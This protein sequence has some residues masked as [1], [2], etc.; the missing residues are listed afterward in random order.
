[1]VAPAETRSRRP[2]AAA[3]ARLPTG[4]KL[5]A[6]LSAALLP[7]ALIITFAAYQTTRASD[8]ENRTRLRVAAAESARTLTIELVG[9]MNALR[10][11]LEAVESDPDDRLACAR[12]RG[13]FAP[14][15]TAGG[16]FGVYDAAGNLRCGTA[17]GAAV[18]PGESGIV[19]D[20]DPAGGLTLA[21]A[22]STG[23]ARAAAF[24]PTAFLAEVGRPSGFIPQFSARLRGDDAA[25]Y[26]RRLD[27]SPLARRDSIVEPIGIEGLALEME[28]PAAP[29][30]SPALIAML[31]PLLMWLVAAAVGWFV[32]DRLLIRP[33]RRLSR[34][35]QLY[36]PGTPFEAISIG[37][38]P[39]QEIRELDQ[40]FLALGRTVVAHESD[41][42]DG[43]VR[44]TRLT[45]E[46][47]H[48]V[49]NNLQVIASLI[50]FHARSAAD[51]P[52]VTAAYASIQRRVDALAVVHRHH[53]AEMEVNRGLNLRSVLGEL[54]ASIRAGAVEPRTRVGVTLEIEPFYAS[55]DTAVAVSFLLT[56]LM[57]LAMATGP[58]VPA[59]ISLT[60]AATPE[61]AVLRLSSPALVE[62]NDIRG[63][64]A[65]RYGRVIEGLS[66]QLRSKL[67]HDPLVGAFEIEIA[68]T[69]RD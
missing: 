38:V 6:I 28:M 12:V 23:S 52:D 24:F 11:T 62:G 22:G 39:A 20:V 69:G 36:Q 43:L 21:I 46:V 64:L 14:D 31:L 18:S 49:K 7:F 5:F 3:F 55:Q 63:L 37:R 17:L 54:V 4:A 33:L 19:I 48:R 61:R 25:L 34:S 65:T 66:R 45:R 50:N 29:I 15:I 47:H 59:R 30:T 53:F 44:Q 56:E 10:S 51:N 32:V 1:M 16:A 41:L 8:V 57:E 58:T 26:L 27:G 60:S 9:D 35:V 2:I 40:A 68:V 13:V 67:F 42:A